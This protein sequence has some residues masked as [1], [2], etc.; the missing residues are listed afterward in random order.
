MN[1]LHESLSEA[2]IEESNLI[3]KLN[4]MRSKNLEIERELVSY[5]YGTENL[6]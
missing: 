6:V 4:T 5:R 3:E 1:V 2:N